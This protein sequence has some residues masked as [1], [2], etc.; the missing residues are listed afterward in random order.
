MK[1][2]L[3]FHLAGVILHHAHSYP[4]L[5]LELQDV[6]ASRYSAMIGGG[7]R[8]EH[9]HQIKVSYRTYLTLHHTNQ[10]AKGL[11]RIFSFRISLR[12]YR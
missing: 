11:Y 5:F 10:S 4:I 1:S 12:D 2:S 9:S 7:E 3:I 6:I 8:R